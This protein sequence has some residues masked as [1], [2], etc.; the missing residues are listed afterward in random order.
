MKTMSVILSKQSVRGITRSG[1]KATFA[2]LAFPALLLASCA[3]PKYH[4]H[5]DY[6][7]LKP[8]PAFKG[9]ATA[10]ASKGSPRTYAPYPSADRTIAPE[11]LTASS[12][13]TETQLL[14]A[15]TSPT[16]SSGIPADIANGYPATQSAGSESIA[17]N[18]VTTGSIA[19]TSFTHEKPAT[20]LQHLNRKELVRAL[21]QLRKESRL[22]EYEPSVN[23]AVL[24]AGQA[25]QKLDAEVIVAIAF[26]A[27]GITLS[28]LGAIS[29]AF[30]IAGV[31][32]LGIGIFFFVDWLSKR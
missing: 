19:T 21:R 16:F 22:R 1:T 3:T 12:E 18:S 17:T 11:Y 9:N 29:A 2:C 6:Y 7:T 14:T 27:V 23:N 31:L 20:P 15:S 4:Y 26:G 5:F 24:P 30:W 10:M 25:A 8:E 32:C 28:L 13:R